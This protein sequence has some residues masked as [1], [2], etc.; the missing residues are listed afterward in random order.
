MKDLRQS[1]A[2]LIGA[3]KKIAGTNFGQIWGL[4]RFEAVSCNPAG[5]LQ[6]SLGPF[7]PKCPGSVPRS[8]CF[9]G[10]SGPG[11]R[12]G[13]TLGTLFGHSGARGPK[14]PRDTLG[15]R[16]SCSRPGGLQAVRGWRVLVTRGGSKLSFEG[17]KTLFGHLGR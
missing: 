12:S 11:L 15:P 17:A 14:G 8:G 7:G 5:L 6:E 16:D 10:P 3:P 9:W 4:G 2:P 13:D 1:P